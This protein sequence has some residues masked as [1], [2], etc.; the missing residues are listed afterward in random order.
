M[1]DE[2]REWWEATASDFK[3]ESDIDVGLHWGWSGSDDR[4]RDD[5]RTRRGR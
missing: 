5:A 3:E 1:T 2:V 4:R